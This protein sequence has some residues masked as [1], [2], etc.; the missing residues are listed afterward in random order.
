MP[1]SQE[2]HTCMNPSGLRSQGTNPLACLIQKR[3]AGHSDHVS[4]VLVLPQ[5]PHRHPVHQPQP[6]DGHSL[7]CHHLPAEAQHVR[8]VLVSTRLLQRI[9]E[10]R[11]QLLG[12]GQTTAPVRNTW[13]GCRDAQTMLWSALLQELLTQ[14][15]LHPA[16]ANDLRAL[17]ELQ[18]LH[19][20]SQE[21]VRRQSSLLK[22]RSELPSCQAMSSIKSA[23]KWK[24]P[25]LKC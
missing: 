13:G 16:A 14:S 24:D 17:G 6:A 22:S 15:A 5:V 2:Q 19:L 20:S 23:P 21:A 11:H 7:Q 3:C 12:R 18:G 25:K 10:V 8:C 9:H 4:H 1:A